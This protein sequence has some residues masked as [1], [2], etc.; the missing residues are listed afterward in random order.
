MFL[1]TNRDCLFS[2]KDLSLFVNSYSSSNRRD[3]SNISG[4]PPTLLPKHKVSDPKASRITKGQPS[5]SEGNTKTS[6]PLTMLFISFLQP[7]NVMFFM[8]RSLDTF[9]R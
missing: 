6:M 8:F 2:I 7:V 4:I 5:Y 1:E 9:L 3:L